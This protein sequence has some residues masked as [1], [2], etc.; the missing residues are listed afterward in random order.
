[1]SLD[2]YSVQRPAVPRGDKELCVAE[3][4]LGFH[5]VLYWYDTHTHIQ[6]QTE[7]THSLKTQTTVKI[8][9]IPTI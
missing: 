4:R 8:W 6:T 3:G 1:M 5:G 9:P 7:D 2:L